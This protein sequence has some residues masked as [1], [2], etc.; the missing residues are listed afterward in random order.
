MNVRIFLL[1]LAAAAF[2]RI[3]DGDQQ[4]MQAA[5]AK[6]HAK[7]LETGVARCL[8]P[9]STPAVTDA[10]TAKALEQCP[11][12]VALTSSVCQTVD[13]L[14]LELQTTFVLAA[15]IPGLAVS[16]AEDAATALAIEED[17]HNSVVTEPTTVTDLHSAGGNF[18][19]SLVEP[20]LA[21]INSDIS[22]TLMRALLPLESHGAPIPMPENL[23]AGTWRATSQLGQSV[24]IIVTRSATVEADATAENETLERSFCIAAAPGG[25]RWCFVRVDIATSEI[26]KGEPANDSA[27]VQR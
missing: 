15:T 17:K 9:E 2:M 20:S 3:W 11:E 22:T 10:Q 13:T 26:A 5:L 25:L 12:A 18:T 6:R 24:V 16:A 23:A 7:T 14:P 1:V 27:P 4:A 21:A 19:A 8:T